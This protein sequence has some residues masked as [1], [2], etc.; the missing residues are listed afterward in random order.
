MP[1]DTTTRSGATTLARLLDE[2][3]AFSPSFRRHYSTHLAMMLVAL[4]QLGAPP[5]VLQSTFDA[6]AR[7]EA[8]RRDDPDVLAERRREVVAD[9]IAA[10]VRSRVPELATGPH[11]Q[12]FHPMIRLA[13][14]LEVGHEG[15]VAAALLD[16]ERR[17]Q[18]LPAPALTRGERRLTD[19]AAELAAQPPGTWPRTFDLDGIARR[20]ELRAAL[21]DVRLDD[22][23]LD[24]V[25]GFAIAAHTVAD[26]FITLHLVTGARALRTV[27]SWVEDDTA[28]RLVAHAAPAMAVAYAAV[29]APPLAGPAELDA[30]RRTVQWTRE[31]IA[32]QAV[33]DP[34]PHVVKLATV[35]LSED[36]RTGDLLY[37]HSAAR[38]VGLA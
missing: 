4:D 2:E 31:E 16:W 20:P 28:R 17:H 7:S 1:S 34:D 9:G 18:V 30:L 38:V 24:D 10:T 15:Q 23:T 19:V 21:V 35:A 27:T 32:E 36:A 5:E 13:Y 12:L 26:D 11:S 29:G 22:T 6:H 25:S 8:E 3:L 37:L 14:A 33:A